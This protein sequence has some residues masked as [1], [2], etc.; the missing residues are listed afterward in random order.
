M[1]L[2]FAF[3]VLYYNSLGRMALIIGAF[4]IVSYKKL[5]KFLIRRDMLKTELWLWFS[6]SSASLAKL[7]KDEKQ[8]TAVPEKICHALDYNVSG[9]I[10]D[11]TGIY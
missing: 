3:G 7:G 5:W 1:D 11:V 4:M 9:I 8:A 10:I 2:K 6:G